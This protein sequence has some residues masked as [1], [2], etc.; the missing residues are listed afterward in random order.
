[1]GKAFQL[2]KKKN[3][4]VL[5]AKLMITSEFYLRLLN[6]FKLHRIS[7]CMVQTWYLIRTSRLM[8]SVLHRDGHVSSWRKVV[9]ENIPDSI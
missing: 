3:F 6:H 1:M 8:Q 7:S 2:K 5:Y 4:I 9:A